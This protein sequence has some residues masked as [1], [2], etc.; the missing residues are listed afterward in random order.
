MMNF[1]L[2]L[3]LGAETETKFA[4]LAHK[5]TKATDQFG[6]RA[7]SQSFLDNRPMHTRPIKTDILNLFHG[8]FTVIVTAKAFLAEGT[9]N[10]FIDHKVRQ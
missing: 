9:T 7:I 10:R 5:L 2:N 4:F 3:F 8:N 6:L 1:M